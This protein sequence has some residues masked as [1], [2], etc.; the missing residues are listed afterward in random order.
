VFSKRRAASKNPENSRIMQ[1][2]AR[3]LLNKCQQTRRLRS[4]PLRYRAALA[5]RGK[6]VVFPLVCAVHRE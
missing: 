6:T 1:A 2:R 5:E 4:G 3:G